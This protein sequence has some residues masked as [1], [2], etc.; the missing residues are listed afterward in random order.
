HD[1]QTWVHTSNPSQHREQDDP[2]LHRRTP[3]MPDANPLT[4]WVAGLES[5]DLRVRNEAARRIW[6]RF[7]EE[8][9]TLVRRRLNAKILASEEEHDIVQSIF[10]GFFEI[11]SRQGYPLR[12]LGELER[13]LRCIAVRKII[14]IIVKHTADCRNV[15]RERSLTSLDPPVGSFPTHR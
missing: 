3:S 9:H 12:E 15:W 6:Q 2:T 10:E 7:A 8:L 1:P 11:Q 5:P 4:R 14:N 13:L